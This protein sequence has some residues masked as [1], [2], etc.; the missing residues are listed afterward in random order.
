[1]RHHYS[2]AVWAHYRNPCH[3]GALDA[4]A[5]DVGTGQVG[6]Q[7][8]GAVLRLQIQVDGDGVIRAARFK[9]YGCG[10]TIAAGSLAAQRLQ[11]GTLAQAQTLDSAALV[12]ALSLPPVKMYCAMLAEDAVKAAIRDYLDKQQRG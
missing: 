4:K 9:A 6:S 11:G 10:A 2:E 1:M 5:P 3:A 12:A 7:A 8:D